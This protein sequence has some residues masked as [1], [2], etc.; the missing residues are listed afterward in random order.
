M[1]DLVHNVSKMLTVSGS[2]SLVLKLNNVSEIANF[3]ITLIAK[4]C[5]GADF[6]KYRP[7]NPHIMH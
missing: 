4:K 6:S 1:H 7:C 2:Q 3:G 5:P